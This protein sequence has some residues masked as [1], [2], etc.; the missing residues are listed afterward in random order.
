MYLL[1]TLIFQTLLFLKFSKPDHN[2]LS[3]R[4]GSQ[5]LLVTHNDCK[6]KEQKTLTQSNK[7]SHS[8]RIRTTINRNNKHNSN[9]FLKSTSYN[10][11]KIKILSDVF[12]K[13]RTLFPS[14][15]RKQKQIMNLSTKVTSKDYC[16]SALNTVKTN[17]ND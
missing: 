15:R 11:N 13:E 14:L 5:D 8:T 1:K 3:T 9:T 17:F 12:R 4:T 10:A 6:E 2:N 7:P 16:T